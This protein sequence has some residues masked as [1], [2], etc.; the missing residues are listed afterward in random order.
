MRRDVSKHTEWYWLNI[1][2]ENGEIGKQATWQPEES[3]FGQQKKMLY[4]MFFGCKVDFDKD[5]KKKE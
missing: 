5:K 4:N 2:D 3:L 1:Y